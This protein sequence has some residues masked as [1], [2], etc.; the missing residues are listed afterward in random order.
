MIFTQRMKKLFTKATRVQCMEFG[1]LTILAALAIALYQKEWGFVVAATVLT[2]VTMI[3]PRIFHPFAVVWFGL[4]GILSA[5]SSRIL[6][7]LAFFLVVVP[8]AFFRRGSGKDQL[9]TRQFRK[10]NASVMVLRDHWYAKDDL[11]NTF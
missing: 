2:L 10:D 11:I 4:S 9:K 6:L 5:V 7:G 1:Q 3:V 8:V